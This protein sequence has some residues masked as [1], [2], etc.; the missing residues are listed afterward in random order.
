MPLPS[1]AVVSCELRRTRRSRRR[2]EG[3]LDGLRKFGGAVLLDHRR[4]V[5]LEQLPR[6]AHVLLAGANV[7]DGE[8]QR[9]TAVEF[10][11]RQEHFSRPVDRVEQLAVQLFEL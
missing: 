10:C 6:A 8:A 1:L 9:V 2:G 7:T 3:G 5:L 4:S 11:V